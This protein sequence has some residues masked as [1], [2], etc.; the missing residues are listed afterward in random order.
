MPSIDAARSQQAGWYAGGDVVQQMGLTCQ[1]LSRRRAIFM[2]CYVHK[3]TTFRQIGTL[4]C[5]SHH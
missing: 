5:R 3:Q 1:H 2:L 4:R